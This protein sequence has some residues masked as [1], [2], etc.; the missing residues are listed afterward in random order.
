MFVS[1]FLE[2][3][4]YK[5]ES[6]NCVC[7]VWIEP[8]FSRGTVTKARNACGTDYT[9]KVKPR[10]CGGK[11]TALPIAP[12]VSCQ[13]CSQ[14]RRTWEGCKLPFCLFT[15][16][17]SQRVHFRHLLTW[18]QAERR[19]GEGT[20]QSREAPTWYW[21]KYPTCTIPQQLL[22]GVSPHTPF[23]GL[24]TTFVCI[25]AAYLCFAHFRPFHRCFSLR[26][27]QSPRSVKPLK[28]HSAGLCY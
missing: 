19:C 24:F 11:G 15:P 12:L 27:F 8:G 17:L 2:R 13:I 28:T 16:A 21:G 6:I 18:S 23:F 5:L 22:G 26:R 4:Q 9:A 7:L 20:Q 1:I 14:V 25:W 3:F 10:G